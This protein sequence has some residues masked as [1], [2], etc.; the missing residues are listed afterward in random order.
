MNIEPQPARL[1]AGMSNY[2]VKGYHVARWWCNGLLPLWGFF[3]NDLSDWCI[4][5]FDVL[6]LL[7]LLERAGKPQRGESSQ[8]WAQ[9]IDVSV[10]EG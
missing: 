10:G 9:P 7:Q 5:M 3:L 1:P 2:E 6:C 8:Q 4:F